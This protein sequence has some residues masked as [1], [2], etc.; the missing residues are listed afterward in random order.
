MGTK[1]NIG[2]NPRDPLEGF[3]RA[4]FDFNDAIDQ[5]V[6]KPVAQVYA[7]VTPSFVQTGV[8]NFFGNIGDIYTAL[9]NLLQGKV[10]DGSSDIMRVALNSTFG[11]AGL[12]DIGSPAGLSKHKEDF[13]QTLGVWGVRSGP[14]LVLPVLGPTTVRDA[15]ATP[16]DYYGDAWSYY[17]PVYIRNTGSLV[18]LVDKR[19]SVLDA[20]SLIEEAALDRY[21]FIRDAY[22]QRRASQINPNQD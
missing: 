17:K 11:L 6:L 7:N 1:T 9:N 4:M 22:L 14:Y 20:G 10:G 21:V 8:G 16:L 12:L 18:R 5:A 13:G 3:N 19:A 15:V 2:Q